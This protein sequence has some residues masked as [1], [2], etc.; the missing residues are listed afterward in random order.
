MSLLLLVAG[1]LLYRRQRHNAGIPTTRAAN[2]ELYNS[3]SD[4]GGGGG[5]GVQ[6]GGKNATLPRSRV[7]GQTTGA[8]ANGGAG[9]AGAASN[10]P[11]YAIPF[12]ETGEGAVTSD[13]AQQ[14]VVA[15][16]RG[17]TSFENAAYEYLEVGDETNS[18][19][20]AHSRV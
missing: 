2:N 12:D 5:G 10:A 18:G 6:R 1:F 11:L 4:S 3:S 13:N 20:A 7:V 16:G 14:F 19:I 15:D 9:G 8:P 17:T